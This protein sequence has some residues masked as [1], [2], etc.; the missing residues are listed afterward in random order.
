[1]G[2]TR[3][4]FVAGSAAGVIATAIG[5]S[6]E[7]AEA[8]GGFGWAGCVAADADAWGAYGVWDGAAG[9]AGGFGGRVCGGGE[10]DAGTRCRPKDAAQAAGNW[11]QAM[12]PVYER[13]QGPRKVAI[14]DADVPATVWNPLM[15]RVMQAS[16]SSDVR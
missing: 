16:R 6:A 13:R 1:M 11:Q 7:Q 2:R 5:W 3:R 9:G 4:E 14:T 8:A 10:A 15:M 12:A